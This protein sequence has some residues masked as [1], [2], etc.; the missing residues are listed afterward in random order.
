[1]TSAMEK[2]FNIA[3]ET[4]KLYA[5]DVSSISLTMTRHVR[6]FFKSFSALL[7]E[8]DDGKSH[9]SKPKFHC[10]YKIHT[11][12]SFNSWPVKKRTRLPRV[13]QG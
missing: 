12:T 6:L 2:S 1:M 5:L 11:L 10:R 13:P 3:D 4:S 9:Q 7:Q 8:F